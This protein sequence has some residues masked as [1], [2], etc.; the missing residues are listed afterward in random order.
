MDQVIRVEDKSEGAYSDALRE[1][2]KPKFSRGQRNTKTVAALRLIRAIRKQAEDDGKVEEFREY[3][4]E[5]PRW[6]RIWD[7]LDDYFEES[8]N[9]LDIRAS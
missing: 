3:W 2:K 5:E 9:R 7:E 8:P 4:L 6:A 1:A